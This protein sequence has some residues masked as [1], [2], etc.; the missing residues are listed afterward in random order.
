MNTTMS[1]HTTTSILREDA[2]RIP[3]TECWTARLTVRQESGEQIEIT[4]F[5]SDPEKL[6]ILDKPKAIAKGAQ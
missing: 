3:G 5:G 1:I 4:F 2:R 6:Q